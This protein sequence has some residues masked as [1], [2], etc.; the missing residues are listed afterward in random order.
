MMPSLKC[1]S[2]VPCWIRPRVA[3]SQSGL[4]LLGGLLY[5]RLF[6]C[7]RVFGWQPQSPAGW[8]VCPPQVRQTVLLLEHHLAAL[9]VYW[10]RP[11]GALGGWTR[12]NHQP[13]HA[14]HGIQGK[15]A[16]ALS[17]SAGLGTAPGSFRLRQLPLPRLTLQGAGV[18][19][20]VHR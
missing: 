4:R 13:E 10:I 19:H 16:D 8:L 7:W 5:W 2:R 12:L 9:Q 11:G 6:A 20:G 1:E 3:A 18:G 15:P 17:K 14:A